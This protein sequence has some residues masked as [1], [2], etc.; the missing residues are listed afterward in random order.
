MLLIEENRS[1]LKIN[2][3]SYVQQLNHKE[4]D[5]IEYDAAHFF[6]EDS[7]YNHVYVLTQ[8]HETQAV[9]V[10]T[11]TQSHFKTKGGTK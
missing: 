2:L 8:L 4:L 1:H 5:S 3:T 7:P 10:L 6:S 9:S 11:P